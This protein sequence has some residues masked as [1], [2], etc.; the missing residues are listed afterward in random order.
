MSRKPYGKRTNEIASGAFDKFHSRHRMVNI[1]M[2]VRTIRNQ[3]SKKA[4]ACPISN[5]TGISWK[6]K[7]YFTSKKKEKE[8]EITIINELRLLVDFYWKIARTYQ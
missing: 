3:R 1:L 5:E 2:F 8:K 7:F 4:L 6:I